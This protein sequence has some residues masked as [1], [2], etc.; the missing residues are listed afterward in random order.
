MLVR[1]CDAKRKNLRTWNNFN[2]II[3]QIMWIKTQTN[4]VTLFLRIA[5]VLKQKKY[6]NIPKQK[7]CDGKTDRLVHDGMKL[8]SI[9][10]E[11]SSQQI[12]L[13]D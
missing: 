7:N 11:F 5:Q 13:N 12:F 2:N 1:V 3:P 10:Y 4:T 9:K 8:R 6:F